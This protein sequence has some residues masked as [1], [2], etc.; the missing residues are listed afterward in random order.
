MQIDILIIGQGISGT[1]LSWYLQQEGFSFL[2]ID[3][4]QSNTASKVAAGA[5][6][7]VTGRRIVKDLMIDEVL[8]FALDAYQQLGEASWR[9][10]HRTK[11]CDRLLPYSTNETG[12]RQT[13]LQKTSNTCRSLQMKTISVPGPITISA[14]GRS[15]QLTW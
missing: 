14:M 7:P 1:F 11:E 12:F 6:N 8:P 15:S 4:P 13:V 9:N 10:R 5:I 3:Q 2:V